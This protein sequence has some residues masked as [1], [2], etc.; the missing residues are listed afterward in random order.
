MG[1]TNWIPG[2]VVLGGGLLAGAIAALKLARGGA[3]ASSE[4]APES[5]ETADLE[6][7]DLHAERDAV[8]AQLR[9]LDDTASKREA[10][11]L[12]RDRYALELQL[13]KVLM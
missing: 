11:Q 1:E 9:E 13:A 10:A 4:A 7:R 5:L 3:P 6:L 2:L 12:A 8:L